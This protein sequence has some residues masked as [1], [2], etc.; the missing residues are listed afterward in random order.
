M[1]FLP[2]IPKCRP[3]WIPTVL[4]GCS[5]VLPSFMALAQ[6]APSAA[7]KPLTRPSPATPAAPPASPPEAA[8][9]P[10]TVTLSNGKLTITA[11]NSD[12]TAILQQVAHSSGMSIDGLGKST[13]VFGVYGPG[14]P[15]DVLADLLDGSDYNFAMLG[16]GGGSAPAKLVLSEKTAGPLTSAR[17]GAAS[18]DDSSDADSDAADDEPLG[19]GAIPHPSPQLTDTTDPQARSER[20]LDRLQQM[21]DQMQQQQQQQQANPQ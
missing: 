11:K 7:A 16:G 5:A 13:R 8:P 20:N 21:H 2:A 17:P 12:L 10:A 9:E 1:E 3:A 4:L 6:A 15:R 19:P 14:S 18:D